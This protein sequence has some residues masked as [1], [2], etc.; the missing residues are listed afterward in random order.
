MNRV[1]TVLFTSKR[2]QGEDISF[3]FLLRKG[4][5]TFKKLFVWIKTTEK[6]TMFGEGED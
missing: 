3:T 2:A 1:Q 6:L 4:K 5:E